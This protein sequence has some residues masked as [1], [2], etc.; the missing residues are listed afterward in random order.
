MILLFNCVHTSIV[1]VKQHFFLDVFT[2]LQSGG[3]FVAWEALD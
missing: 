1:D 3:Q 2:E